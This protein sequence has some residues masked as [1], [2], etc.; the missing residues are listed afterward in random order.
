[1]VGGWALEESFWVL[2]FAS[3]SLSGSA[4]LTA[5]IEVKR[6]GLGLGV[7]GNEDEKHDKELC[8]KVEEK[9]MEDDE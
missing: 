2:D 4:D 3:F 1:M 7:C 9:A 8:E 5:L 6:K